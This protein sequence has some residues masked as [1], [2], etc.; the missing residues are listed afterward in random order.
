MDYKDFTVISPLLISFG[1]ANDFF[2]SCYSIV[3]WLNDSKLYY[4]FVRL[5]RSF[6]PIG[7]QEAKGI[8]IANKEE[9]RRRQV[10]S[11]VTLF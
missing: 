9:G 7:F 10:A 1:F 5:P 11:E 2:C 4:D 8:T 3:I 6:D